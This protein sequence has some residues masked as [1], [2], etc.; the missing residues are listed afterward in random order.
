MKRL[1]VGVYNHWAPVGELVP[2]LQSIDNRST[3]FHILSVTGSCLIGLSPT[4]ITGRI[5]TV[6]PGSIWCTTINVVVNFHFTEQGSSFII[7][8]S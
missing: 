3:P 1:V 8:D 5:Q 4:C 7:E 2:L 6:A